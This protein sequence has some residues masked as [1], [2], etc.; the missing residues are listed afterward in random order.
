VKTEAVESCPVCHGAGIRFRWSLKDRWFGAQGV[1]KLDRCVRPTCGIV[2]LNPRPVESEIAGLYDSYYTHSENDRPGRFTRKNPV[3]HL[4]P[5]PWA[6]LAIERRQRV[7]PSW[8][9]DAPGLALDV[10]CGSGAALLSLSRQGWKVKGYELDVIA[11][12]KARALVGCEIVVGDFALVPDSAF[13]LVVVSHVLEHVPNPVAF[14]KECANKL[15]PGGILLVHTPNIDSFSAKAF[16]NR[17]RGLEPPRHLVLF[18]PK[19]ISLI[20]REVGLDDVRLATNSTLDAQ[21]SLA[22]LF[23]DESN[24]PKGLKHFSKP[25]KALTVVLTQLIVDVVNLGGKRS[26]SEIMVTA[27]RSL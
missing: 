20:F 12:Q 15:L 5:T 26:G 18:S 9:E 13:N 3:R 1:W 2:W 17:W 4:L 23:S 24:W 6:A 25:L 19:S 21:L 11:A 10:G 22:S 27:R 8:I 14:L 7:V 16:G